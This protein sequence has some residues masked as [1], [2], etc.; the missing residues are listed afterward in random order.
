MHGDHELQ[1]RKK[2]HEH[3]NTSKQTADRRTKSTEMRRNRYS[4]EGVK[5]VTCITGTGM[6]KERER[7]E[8]SVY[9]G[10]SPQQF[11]PIAA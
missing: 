8:S 5:L 1:S 9:H 4:R 10:K 6:T 7:Q 3:L 11:K 2:Q